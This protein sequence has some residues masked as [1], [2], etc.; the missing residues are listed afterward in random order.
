VIDSRHGTP[1]GIIAK[2]LLRQAMEARDGKKPK[3]K[4]SKTER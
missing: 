3:K 4:T 2:I 1:A